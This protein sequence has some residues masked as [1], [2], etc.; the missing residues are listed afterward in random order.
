ME[1]RHLRY[2][3]S[4][5][6]ALH[7]GQAAAK[8]HITQPSLSHQIKLLEAELRTALLYRTK[9]RV[10]LT[11]AGR[12]FLEEARDVLARADR[13]AMVARRAGRATE[14]RLRVAVGYCMD[15]SRVSEAVSMFNTRHPAIRV[16]LQTM[17]V[18]SQ[19]DALCRQALDVGFVRPPITNS[20]LAT[21]T[22][23]SEPLIA[24]VRVNHRLAAKRA[25]ATSYPC[26]M[27]SSSKPVARPVSF[28]TRRMRRITS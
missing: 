24:A 1:L 9:R 25:R 7:F 3:V 28:P 19:V 6:E 20:G 23:L 21:E 14:G 15:Q 11:D 26:I 12:L 17:A 27:T 5:A 10:E 2:F 18:P 22:L 8:L 16:E 4:V 13:A